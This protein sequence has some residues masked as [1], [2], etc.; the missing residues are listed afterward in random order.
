MN[1]ED[2]TSSL[3]INNTDKNQLEKLIKKG[4]QD[5]YWEGFKKGFKLGVNFQ[6]E[7]EKGPDGFKEGFWLK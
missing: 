6:K 7:R 2:F 3:Q 1:L 5:A 4:L